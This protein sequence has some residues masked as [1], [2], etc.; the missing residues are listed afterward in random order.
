VAIVAVGL[1]GLAFALY[2]LAE[3]GAL[4][5]VTEYDDGPQARH[6]WHRGGYRH[7]APV[8][9]SYTRYAEGVAASRDTI[10]PAR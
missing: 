2:Q 3:P 9:V 1:L 4:Y 6:P 7:G 5:G 10:S 8:I